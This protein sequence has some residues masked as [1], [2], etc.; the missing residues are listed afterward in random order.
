MT[1]LRNPYEQQIAEASN[2]QSTLQATTQNHELA[3]EAY[4]TAQRDSRTT[5]ES[6][7]AEE[8]E[9]NLD[10]SYTDEYKA[11]KNAETRK[12]IQDVALIRAR[13]AGGPL[14][15]AWRAKVNEDSDLFN[16]QLAFEQSEARFKA[17][18]M[19][20]MLQGSLLKAAAIGW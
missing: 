16:A 2:L 3:I 17:V 5:N 1:Q 14:A 19:A 10:L 9:F 8:A 7:A 11:A 15:D 20:A 12:M 4:R 18:C 13:Q 6:Y